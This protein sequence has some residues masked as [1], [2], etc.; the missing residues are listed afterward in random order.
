MTIKKI[1]YI[2]NKEDSLIYTIVEKIDKSEFG[3]DK[4]DYYNYEKYKYHTK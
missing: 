2:L 3:L 1:I 4:E